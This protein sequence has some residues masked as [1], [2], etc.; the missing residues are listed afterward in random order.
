MFDRNHNND[1]IKVTNTSNDVNLEGSLAWA[2]R[3]A[4]NLPGLDAIDLSE[5]S[6]QTIVG[7]SFA[8]E[9][10]NDIRTALV[11]FGLVVA[12]RACFP[13]AAFAFLEK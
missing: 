1:A 12:P 2:I 5:I 9:A 6:G 7:H 8:I 10:G 11:C 13:D 4:G 3:E